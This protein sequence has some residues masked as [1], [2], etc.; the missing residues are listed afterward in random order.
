VLD[1]F[2][3]S[4]TTLTVARKL[5]RRYLGFELSD[6]YADRARKRLEAAQPGQDLEGGPDPL[7]GGRRTPDQPPA[8]RRATKQAGA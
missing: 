6:D 8:R 7:A 2:S 4:G 1:P 5:H 3:G